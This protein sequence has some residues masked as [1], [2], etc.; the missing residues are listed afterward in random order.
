MS[1]HASK[2]MLADLQN[3][4]VLSLGSAHSFRIAPSVSD[5]EVWARLGETGIAI[6]ASAED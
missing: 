6:M 2:G 1:N 3:Q 4:L 5:R